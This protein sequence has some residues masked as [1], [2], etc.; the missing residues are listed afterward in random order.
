MSPDSQKSSLTVIS[1]IVASI[2]VTI[3]PSV[4]LKFLGPEKILKIYFMTKSL[5]LQ[6]QASAVLSRAKQA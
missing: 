3:N 2:A 5:S 1:V 4:L 6:D